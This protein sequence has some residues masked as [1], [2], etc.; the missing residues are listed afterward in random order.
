MA[1][2]ASR[3]RQGEQLDGPRNH[4]FSAGIR[5]LVQQQPCDRHGQ[6]FFCP[7]GGRITPAALLRTGAATGVTSDETP[8]RLGCDQ[9]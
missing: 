9:A 6:W 2:H 5:R 3:L 4:N 1:I 8:T 7:L